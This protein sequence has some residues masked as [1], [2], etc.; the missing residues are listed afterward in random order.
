MDEHSLATIM[1]RNPEADQKEK[2][3]N[4]IIPSI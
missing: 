2:T 1:S 3:K 4:S